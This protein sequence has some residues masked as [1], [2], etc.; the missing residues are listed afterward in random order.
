MK[1]RLDSQYTFVR[2]CVRVKPG[3]AFLI[4]WT[5]SSRRLYSLSNQ[6]LR[7]RRSH[8]RTR[9][10]GEPINA[11]EIFSR[12]VGSTVGTLPFGIWIPTRDT[13]R[14][15]TWKEASSLLP[16]QRLSPRPP[17]CEDAQDRSRPWPHP[18]LL[19]YI[20]LAEKSFGPAHLRQR[21]QPRTPFYVSRPRKRKLRSPG[22]RCGGAGR[23][24]LYIHTH[25]CP[26]VSCSAGAAHGIRRRRKC[27]CRGAAGEGPPRQASQRSWAQRRDSSPPRP[28]SPAQPGFSPRPDMDFREILLIASKGQG[29]NHVP[30]S[31]RACSR[32]P[33]RQVRI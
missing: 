4:P 1:A 24:C 3:S 30:V 28:E 32:N 7:T 15:H 21:Q 10:P 25:I 33:G 20:W 9:S 12:P 27:P 26:V 18:Q 29:V 31:L 23:V 17:G 19:Y 14:T 6:H 13:Y 2:Q 11:T 8:V 16:P 5:K 22:Q